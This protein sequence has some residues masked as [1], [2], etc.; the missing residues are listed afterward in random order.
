MIEPPPEV[1]A[2]LDPIRERFD[3]VSASRV[4]AHITVTP[5]FIEAPAPADEARVADVIRGIPSMRLR[6]GM[7]RRFG[8]SSVIYLPVVNAEGIGRLRELLLATGLFRLDLP[9][10]TEFVPHLTISEFGATPEAALSTVIPA[11]G[12]SA[13]HVGSVA[14][15]VPDEEFQF[16]VRRTFALGADE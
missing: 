16:G 10:T 7:P 8:G 5:P 15:M 6:L 2:V 4:G 14:W 12:E 3:P 1:A 9:H 13:F 11:P